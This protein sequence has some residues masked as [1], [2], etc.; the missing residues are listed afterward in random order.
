MKLRVIEK[1][2]YFYPQF[3][4]KNRYDWNLNWKNFLGH[5]GKSIRFLKPNPAEQFINSVEQSVDS[6]KSKKPSVKVV[7]QNY[8]EEKKLK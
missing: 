4:G 1:D 7:Y 2:G 3:Y 6:V 5:A 8:K